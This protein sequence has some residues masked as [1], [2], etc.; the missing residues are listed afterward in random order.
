[1]KAGLGG[2]HVLIDNSECGNELPGVTSR[3]SLDILY[4][5]FVRLQY[6]NYRFVYVQYPKCGLLKEII[7]LYSTSH[8]QMTWSLYGLIRETCNLENYTVAVE[9]VSEYADCPQEVGNG[10]RVIH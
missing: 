9:R 5:L 7:A 10:P 2:R 4:S 3:H 8:I 6:A 1:M